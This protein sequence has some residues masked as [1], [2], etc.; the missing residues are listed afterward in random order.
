MK[1]ILVITHQLTHTGAPIVLLDMMQAMKEAGYELKVLSFSEG[2]LQEEVEKMQVPY[3][4]DGDIIHHPEAFLSEAE[5]FDAVIVNT[6]VCFPVIHLLNTIEKPVLWWIHEG[7]QFFDYY[8]KVLPDFANLKPHIHIFS[9]SVYVQEIFKQNYHLDTPIL[10]FGVRDMENSDKNSDP[11]SKIQTEWETMDPHHQKVRFLTVGKYSYV[12]AQDILAETIKKLPADIQKKAVFLFCGDE[13]EKDD[14][15]FG[16]VQ[17]LSEKEDNVKIMPQQS[18]ET[19]LQLMKHMDYLIVP[20]RVDPMPTVAVE[21]M[22]EQKPVIISD[23]CGVARDIE[24]GTDSYLF[25]SENEADLKKTILKSITNTEKTEMGIRARKRYEEEYSLAVFY[26]RVK[27]ILANMI[28]RKKLIFILGSLDIIDIFSYQLIPAFQK[29]GYETMVFSSKNVGGSFGKLHDFLSTK[30]TAV[31][32]FNNQGMHMEVMRGKN[33]WQQ[34]QIPF[35]D[36]LMDHPFAHEAALD[37]APENAIVLCPDKNHMRYLQRFYPQIQTTGFLAHG[38]LTFHTQKPKPIRERRIEA[39]YAGNLS[40]VFIKKIAPDFSQFPFDA[41]KI[42]EDALEELIRHPWKTTEQALEERLLEEGLSFS[43][44]ELNSVIEKLHYID[45]LAVSYYREKTVQVLAES[46]IKIALYGMGWDTC[47]WIHLPN[48]A[49]GGRIPAEDVVEKMQ[50]T[51][52]VLSTM[53]WFKDGTHDRVFNGMLA[54]AV[55]VTDSSVY[56]KENFN[57]IQQ[58]GKEDTRELILFDL[59]RTEDN[60]DYP[61]LN[62]LPHLLK[63]LLAEPDTMQ[64]IADR[65]MARAKK[66][67]TWEARARELDQDLL[68][69]L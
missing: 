67:E 12:K 26:P 20:S 3:T 59:K 44:S 45:L 31:I 40:G 53:T 52:I 32:A 21:A 47:D 63:K 58:E 65:G 66:T 54:G 23:V 14:A 37:E 7:K 38:G 33:T 56:M 25:R 27:H 61:V 51:K 28:E 42:A 39:L 8:Q 29:M 30:V 1:K 4:I 62:E 16:P 5:A 60:T 49:Y 55:A 48:V 19:V 57:G 35:I 10:H 69:Y 17:A 41:K 18:H 9:V 24:D 46:G 50:D 22:M 68:Q 36:I 15:V 64:K 13:C 34:L 43:D 2:D 11:E 6:L